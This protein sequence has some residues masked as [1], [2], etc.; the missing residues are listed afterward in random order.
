MRTAAIRL[1]QG[2]TAD[3]DIEVLLHPAT[4]FDHPRDVVNDPDLSLNEKRALLSS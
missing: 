4:A 3:P 2:A 1:A